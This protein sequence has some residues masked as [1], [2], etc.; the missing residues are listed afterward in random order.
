MDPLLLDGNKNMEDYNNDCCLLKTDIAKIGFQRKHGID[1]G[2]EQERGIR[3]TLNRVLLRYTTA[4]GDDDGDNREN[5]R[6]VLEKMVERLL[7][8]PKEGSKDDPVKLAGIAMEKLQLL[9]TPR[10][11]DYRKLL[12]DAASCTEHEKLQGL[13]LRV[14]KDE[15]ARVDEETLSCA[16]TLVELVDEVQEAFQVFLEQAYGGGGGGGRDELALLFSS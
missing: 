1:I 5:A 13:L 15:G 16:D 9:Q 3:D 7:Q 8:T 4:A 10:R 14:A 6:V 11:V 12:V 2:T